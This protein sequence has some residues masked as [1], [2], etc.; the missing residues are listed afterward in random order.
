MLTFQLLTTFL[1][2]HPAR[3]KNKTN[4][5]PSAPLMPS[6]HNKYINGTGQMCLSELRSSRAPQV[7][8]H[9]VNISEICKYWSFCI[10][11]IVKACLRLLLCYQVVCWFPAVTMNGRCFFK[12]D[13]YYHYDIP[14]T[15]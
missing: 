2:V 1:S 10:I 8:F 14:P 3:K 6:G 7:F 5:V 13:T 12:N 15:I 4:G 9:I 11:W